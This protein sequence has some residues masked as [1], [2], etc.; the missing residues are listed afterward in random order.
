MHHNKINTIF[1][2]INFNKELPGHTDSVYA[3]IALT[4]NRVA[5]G[6][7][8]GTIKIWNCI[9]GCLL[10]TFRFHSSSVNSLAVLDDG[11][12]LSGSWDQTIKVS[13]VDTGQVV[14]S[15]E[16]HEGV[17]YCLEINEILIT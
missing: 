6:S 9:T 17:I 4:S 13:D 8:D 10:D 12:L 15:L 2:R 7:C 16:G 11:K 3:V 1:Y 5:S 14:N